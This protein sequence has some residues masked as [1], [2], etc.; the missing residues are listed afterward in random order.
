MQPII[1]KAAFSRLVADLGSLRAAASFVSRFTDLLDEHILTIE[2]SFRST[3]PE[4][5]R[6]AAQRLRLAA[7]KAGAGRLQATAALL[8]EPDARD[9][10]AA[11]A[12]IGHLRSDARV[13]TL[14]HSAMCEEQA[15][16]ERL[17]ARRPA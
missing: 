13:F 7:A 8:L 5:W 14:A 17:A 15:L 12:L 4:Q 10:R 11:P 16:A 3:D 6:D 9:A 2:R 1:D